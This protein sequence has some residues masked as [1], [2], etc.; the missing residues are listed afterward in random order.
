MCLKNDQTGMDASVDLNT[1]NFRFKLGS[2]AI[3]AALVGQSMATAVGDKVRPQG[4][5]PDIGAWESR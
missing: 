4:N 3:D 5:A 2:P 1:Q